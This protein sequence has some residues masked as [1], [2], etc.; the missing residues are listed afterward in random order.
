LDTVLG[1]WQFQGIWQAQNGRP[2]SIGNVYY[3]GDITRLKTDISSAN[4]D[5]RVFDISGFYFN[6]AAVQTNGVVDPAKQRND[7]RIQLANNIRTLPSQFSGLRGDS[8]NLWDL[9]VSK[10]FSFTESIK[11]QVRGEYLNAFNTPFFNNPNT[12]PRNSDFGRVTSA[13][14]LPRNVQIGLRLVF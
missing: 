13:N 2:F 12:D 1:G 14:N 11:L 4:V 3:N 10:N 7:S 6:D 8:L 9:S 5:G